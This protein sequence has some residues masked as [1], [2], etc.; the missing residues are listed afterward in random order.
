[1]ANNITNIYFSNTFG[2][3]VRT[4]NNLVNAWQYLG[5]YDWD[6]P[7]GTFSIS[8]TGTGF[9]ANTVA[10]FSRETRV[11]GVGSSLY[12]QN[13]AEVGKVLSLTD[14]AN[15]V[16]LYSNGTSIFSGGYQN[17]ASYL[18]GIGYDNVNDSYGI[19]TLAK[20]L[21]A[22]S[23]D[24]LQTANINLI[25]A[26]NQIIYY[27]LS[28]NTAQFSANVTVGN[29]VS[30][31]YIYAANNISTNKNLFVAI[32][33][34]VI[35][36]SYT[37]GLQANTYANTRY[38]SVTDN[39]F[40]NYLQA[41]TNI[42]TDVAV[43]NTRVV[44]D[45]VQANNIILSNTV[46]ANSVVTT[47][48]VH[49]SSNVF[50]NYIQA[51][52]RVVTALVQANT[53]IFTATISANSSVVTP[54]VQA[55][56]NVYTGFLRANNLIV[57]DV[58]ESQ[59]R[60]ITDT[61]LANTR[62]VTA[63][64]Q[65]NTNVIS[66]DVLANTRV[67]TPLVQANNTIISNDILAN[68]RVI[69]PL[70]QANNTVITNTLSANS[71]VTTP[72][73]HGSSNVFTNVLQ[74][75]TSAN[76]R[77]LSVTD[78]T[79]TK[80][81]QA[82]GNAVISGNSN[83][84]NVFVTDTV[85]AR[86]IGRKDA[87]GNPGYDP[88]YNP[89]GIFGIYS[90]ELMVDTATIRQ[91]LYAQGDFQVAGRILTLGEN[92]TLNAN[93]P[94]QNY[95]G[96]PIY[97]GVNRKLRYNANS[98]NANS[99]DVVYPNANNAELNWNETVKR[100]Q[101]RDVDLGNYK[102]IITLLDVIT[103][104]ACTV[105]SQ[106]P[107]CATSNAIHVHASKAYT[108]ANSA[109]DWANGAI[110]L[111]TTP[112]YLNRTNTE[113]GGISTLSV[114]GTT[115]SNFLVA[116]TSITT[117]S[118]QA[119][120]SSNTQNLSVTQKVFA[121][122][123][124]ANN[125]LSVTSTANFNNKLIVSGSTGQIDLKGGAT[126]VRFWDVDN[127]NYWEFVT[128]NSSANYALNLALGNTT[129]VSGTMVPTTISIST[130]TGLTGGGNLS[131]DRT[132]SLTGQALAL[133]NLSSTGIVARTGSA[134][135]S[136]RSIAV[137]GTGI[138]ITNG[139]GVSGDP[140]I[141]S[142]ATASNTPST[143]V[144]RDSSG[145]FS[146]GTITAALIG[147][148]S[149]ATNAGTV[150]GLPVHSGRNNESN[151]VVR[152]DGSGFLQT[153]Y[154]NSS[155][156]DE[157]NNYGPARIWGT[158]GSDSYLRT[159][160][161][162]AVTV[163]YA[164]TATNVSG[165]SVNATTGTFSGL[166]KADGGF[167]QSGSSAGNYYTIRWDG[168]MSINGGT[169]YTNITAGN[170]N[171]YSPTLTGGNASGTWGINITGNAGSAT[172]L[173]GG[174]VSATSG[175]F[176]S[177]LSSSTRI[178]AAGSQLSTSIGT[179]TGS[180]GGIEIYG[181]GSGNAAFMAFHRPGA[182]AAYFGLGNNNRFQVG[183][184]SMGGVAYDLV[185]NDS[186][187]YAINISGNAA[188][189]TTLLGNEGNWASYRSSAVANMLGW[190]NYGNGHVIFDASQS[191]S[192]AGTA[193]NNTNA[194]V[195]WSSTYPT[196]MGWNGASTYGVRV[197]SARVADGASSATLAAKAST[198]AQNGGN[199]GGMTFNWSGQGGQPSW[200]WG[201]NDGSNM[202]VYNPS[203]FSVN[204]ANSAGTSGNITQYTVNQSVGTGNNVQFNS[205][206]VGT[207]GSGTTG[208][209]RATNNITAYYSDDRLKTRLGIIDNALEKVLSLDGFYYQA[210][211]TA[212]S[213]GYESVKEVGVSA[214]QVQAVI[215]E[216][217]VPAPIDDKYLTVRYEKLIPLL[218][219]AIK[220]LK[221]EIN[222]LKEDKND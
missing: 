39:S 71:L 100:W 142:N 181:G 159:Y 129:L 177:T 98:L 52:T 60:V 153:G 208:E 187:T 163:G 180:L 86:Y 94:A 209:I 53:N 185:I 128:P 7:S 136:S 81:L 63:L 147:N 183:G 156:G 40:T 165:G 43:S 34:H 106:V 150:G 56:S 172:N 101:V 148:A 91:D 191:T 89:N 31:N 37:D 70:V 154:I 135:F 69:T 139:D 120:I 213:L 47:P 137:S 35:G 78:K 125:D 199:G 219:E 200:L 77:Y 112:L 149:T 196:L 161:S 51:N 109:Y 218:I 25:Q 117:N 15:N 2:D 134:S 33:S 41:N 186:G 141:T 217:V 202:Y 13:N 174:S 205:I 140:T 110:T 206:G 92:I 95:G 115:F 44:T 122:D 61:A 74:S 29:L 157:G 58:I 85:Y 133:H 12:V 21:F 88:N 151:K 87:S 184:W 73:V 152:T 62:V 9:R 79:F 67:I 143:I 179:A 207:G 167:I 124:Q 64:V 57:T 22:N 24:I 111:G 192:P 3:L 5:F 170:Y 102:N 49:G 220:E 32:N 17:Y 50:S 138:S 162:S 132:L 46:S 36:L 164:G 215:P 80:D 19:V 65:A 72:T 83:S 190:K 123:I 55:S 126:N 1:M 20:S 48:T 195:P 10:V 97:V 84:T 99:F 28:G 82:N 103:D 166:I 76:T 204:Y 175:S 27:N 38:L 193:V 26:N 211:E 171:S 203:N 155:S 118:L 168:A 210:N 107:S 116:N 42:Q 201:G 189:A 30:N 4:A 16:T 214:Q 59:S 66:N 158:N 121:R 144:A 198:L 114:T 105:I 11:E 173:S 75:N 182:Y 146:A 45:F 54:T 197:D 127:S 145:N 176:S 104:T 113:I 216:I 93:S 222:D 178:N 130:G 221:K 23:V 212:Q 160:L 90:T 6:K 108:H 14:R 18:S 131:A 169:Y 68:T 8:S 188:T 96:L 194:A 119:N